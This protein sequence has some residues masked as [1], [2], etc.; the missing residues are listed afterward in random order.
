M[1]KLCFSAA[2]VLLPKTD[3][4]GWAVIAC[5]QYTSQPE[6]WER[7]R[8][9]AGNLPSALD[10]ILPE[11]YLTGDDGDKI[12]KVNAKMNEYLSSDV[13]KEYKNCLILVERIQS[14]GRTR[15]GIVGKIDLEA[16]D[17]RPQSSAQIRATEKTV[18]ERIPPRVKIRQN[19]PLELPH[20]MLLYDDVKNTVIGEALADKDK[21]V[22]YDFDLM[23]GGGHIRG[24]LLSPAAQ[25]KI[26]AALS[27][28][29]DGDK[30]LFCVGD[31]N[32][33]L[34]AAKDCYE[35]NKERVSRYALAEIVNIHD[36]ALDFEPIYRVAFDV[37]AK[38][39]LD[40]FAGY[41][42]GEYTG[43]DAQVFTC[44][45]GG[46]RRKIS[47]KPR[48]KLAVG[49]LQ[50]FLDTKKGLKIDYIHGTDAVNE[51]CKKENTVGFLFDG[52]KKQELFTAVESDGS[53][54]RKTFSMGHA[55]DKRFYLEAR[56][57]TL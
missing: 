25:E 56:K 31:G 6:Y 48:A 29:Q 1:E 24:S 8:K 46:E 13:F 17:Y 19:A 43:A 57:I 22:I 14:D 26:F 40:E 47:V 7:A 2:D 3:P 30:P 38:R 20:A 36:T 44:V 10:L 35:N 12:S 11:V 27:G 16:Y 37:D 21:T 39:L 33:S 5:D 34:A 45:Y 4:S 54:P 49:T 41:C 28:L 42:G 51:I 9:A 53:L 23:C 32:H 50:E 18:L 52:M 15:L 55:D